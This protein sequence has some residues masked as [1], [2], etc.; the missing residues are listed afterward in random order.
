MGILLIIIQAILIFLEQYIVNKNDILNM[1]E[2]TITLTPEQMAMLNKLLEPYVNLYTG[3]N[4]QYRAQIINNGRTLE[5]E[6]NG[7]TNKI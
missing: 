7:N 6:E 3:I 1:N 2:I 4:A 5:G